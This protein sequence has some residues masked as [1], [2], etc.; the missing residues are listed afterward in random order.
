MPYGDGTG[1]WGYGPRSGRRAGFCAGYPVPGYLNNKVPRY[2]GYGFGFRGR[3]NYS[4]HVSG[5][6][7]SAYFPEST[8]ANLSKEEQ[9][10]ILEEELKELEEEKKAIEKRLKDIE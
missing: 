5:P 10:R 9:K 7:G 8:V 2:G 4:P 3:F 6:Y 1:P